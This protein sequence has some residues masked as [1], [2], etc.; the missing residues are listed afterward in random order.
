MRANFGFGALAASPTGASGSGPVSLLAFKRLLVALAVLVAPATMF[1]AAP[2]NP[3]ETPA[4][5]SL[6]GQLLVASPAMGDPRFAGKRFPSVD[7][8]LADGPKFFEE[9]MS[10]VGS[11][12]G[13]EVV[14]TLEALRDKLALDRDAEGRYFIKANVPIPKFVSP[15]GT[16]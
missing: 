16:L 14:R 3:A 5:A 1:A 6:A 13:R 7:E 15:R 12:D 2:P 10:A 8:A 9:L 4:H 11:R